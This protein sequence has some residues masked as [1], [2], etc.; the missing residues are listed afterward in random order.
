MDKEINLDDYEWIH[1]TV[2]TKTEKAV[3]LNVTKKCKVEAVWFPLSQIHRFRNQETS[4]LIPMKDI[5][6]DLE[7]AVCVKKWL[8]D[9]LGVDYE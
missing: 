6:K 9:K 2:I 8:L 3:F 4:V 1:G 5:A 7:V